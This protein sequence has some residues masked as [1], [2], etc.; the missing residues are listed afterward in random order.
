M[1]CL[2]LISHW[3][4]WRQ[5]AATMPPILSILFHRLNDVLNPLLSALP[6][7]S[8]LSFDCRFYCLTVLLSPSS[9]MAKGMISL[10][11]LSFQVRLLCCHLI[12]GTSQTFRFD[13]A[14]QTGKTTAGVLSREEIQQL[15]SVIEYIKHKALLMIA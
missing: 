6:S 3:Q 15:F 1:F 9:P 2:D 8:Q 13:P 14:T 4:S 7:A 5:I 11:I 10:P 12:T